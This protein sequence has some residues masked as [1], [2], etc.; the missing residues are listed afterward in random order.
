MTPELEQIPPDEAKQIEHIIQLTME[1]LQKHYQGDTPRLRGQHAR[2]HACVTATFT[3]R[4]DLPPDMRV[5][6]FATPGQ[7]YQAW[8][9]Y[10]NASSDSKAADSPLAGGVAT[11]GS[12]GMALKIMGVSGSPLTASDGVAAQD[13]LMV[14]HPVFPFANVEDYEAL[15]EILVADDKPDRFFARIHKNAD[16]SPN[17]TD[18][19]SRRALVTFGIVKRIQSLSLTAKPPAYQAPP[20]TP[21]DNQYFGAAPFLFGDGRVMRVSARPVSVVTGEAF[22]QADPH[23]LRT[24]LRKRLTAA[25]A[26]PAIFDFQ[27]QVR[28]ASDLAGKIETDIEDACVQWDEAAHP[29]VKVGTITIPPQDFETSERRALCEGLVFTPWHA[30]AEHRPLGGI[31]RLRRAVYEA[32]ARFRHSPAQAARS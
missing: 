31:N 1:Q 6:V 21:V 28:S 18:P 5:G 10:S 20:A 9:R 16:G 3:V 12:R 30:I 32:S 13:F 29:F 17:V 4:D 25:D 14:N 24:A 11:H 27:I 8:V 23:Y 26:R 19:V 22:D 15:S 2:D 7:Q